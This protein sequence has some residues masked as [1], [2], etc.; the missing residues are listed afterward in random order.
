MFFLL[1]ICMTLLSSIIEASSLLAFGGEGWHQ[2]RSLRFDSFRF[3]RE[4]SFSFVR[5]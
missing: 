4:F 2:R 5:P 3:V 1:F